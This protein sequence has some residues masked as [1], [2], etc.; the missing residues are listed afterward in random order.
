MIQQEETNITDVSEFTNSLIPQPKCPY[1]FISHDSRDA[2]LAE[3][4]CKLLSSVSA[5]VLKSFRSSDKK[6]NQGIL[7]GVE[8]FPEIMK[9]LDE[10]TDVICLLTQNSINRPWILYEAGVAK[11]K[12]NSTMTLGIA[13]GVPLS[14]V[15][16]GPFAQFQNCA[17][18]EDSLSKLVI[19]LVRKI[20]NSEPEIEVIKP[21]VRTF[22]NKSKEILEKEVD[23]DD[24]KELNEKYDHSS[25]VAQLFEEIK[26]MYTELPERI[27]G[28]TQTD[29]KKKFDSDIKPIIFKDLL[30]STRNGNVAFQIALCLIKNEFPWIYDM[31][32]ELLKLRKDCIYCE[33][34]NQKAYLLLDSAF[35]EFKELLDFTIEHPIMREIY[36]YPYTANCIECVKILRMNIDR[37]MMDIEQSRDYYSKISKKRL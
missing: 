19:Q 21:Q 23:S 6:G 2:E 27:D 9:K 31:G 18:D 5:G 13:I 24:K 12:V 17:D 34:N 4:F 32:I 33:L 16:V 29:S 25:D 30:Y 8:W 28:R 20:P 11:G 14:R 37:I 10:A 1:V 35:E 7:Y 22:I 15:N 26:L 36:P 3:C